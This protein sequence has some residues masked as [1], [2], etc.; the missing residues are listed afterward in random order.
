MS[1]G[2][3]IDDLFPTAVAKREQEQV[4][5][6]AAAPTV[7][8]AE[9][10]QVKRKQEQT[11]DC[12]DAPIASIADFP[13]SDKKKATY[14]LDAE[15]LDRINKYAKDYGMKRVAIIEKALEEFLGRR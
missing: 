15:L 6:R 12:T 9:T 8:I 5:I 13:K 3:N 2:Y 4:R 7:H 1:K 11:Q 14:E 10:P